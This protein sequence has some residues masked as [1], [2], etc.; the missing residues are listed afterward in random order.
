MCGQFRRTQCKWTIDRVLPTRLLHFLD[1][2]CSNS[3]MYL[4]RQ[5]VYFRSVVFCLTRSLNLFVGRLWRQCFSNI[6]FSDLIILQLPSPFLPSSF[7]PPSSSPSSIPL[8]SRVNFGTN[9]KDQGDQSSLIKETV[10]SLRP[11]GI[12]R[13]PIEEGIPWRNVVSGHVKEFLER[14]HALAIHC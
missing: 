6:L 1:L 2:D 9:L 14:R 10:P 8:L 13:L 3:E 5:I 11:R 7:S 4:L 12:H